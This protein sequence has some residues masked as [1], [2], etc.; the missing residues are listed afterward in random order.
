MSTL[1]QLSP[2]AKEKQLNILRQIAKIVIQSN[3]ISPRM[4]G[5]F[6]VEATSGRSSVGSSPHVYNLTI[7]KDQ[8]SLLE[9]CCAKILEWTI[10]AKQ[11]QQKNIDLEVLQPWLDIACLLYQVC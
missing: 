1:D 8:C 3:R 5:D 7:Y 2:E 9:V 6:R 11:K 10:V 4:I